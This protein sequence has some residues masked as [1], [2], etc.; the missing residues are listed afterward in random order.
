MTNIFAI[1][2]ATNSVTLDN[3]REGE[4]AFTVS[5]SS[6]RPLRARAQVVAEGDASSDWFTLQG[7][8]EREL[9]IAG[10]EQVTV[11][12]K[13]ANEVT[14]GTYVFR[15]NMVGVVNPD[16]EFGE[17]PTVTLDIPEPVIEKKKF[18]WW[19]LIVILMV[20]LI[21]GAA[22]FFLLRG[23]EPQVTLAEV[24][25]NSETAVAGS[26][27]SYTITISNT[28][29]SPAETVVFTNTLPVGTSFS[30]ISGADCVSGEA[31]G[32]IGCTLSEAIS[33]GEASEIDLVL[34]VAPTTRGFITNTVRLGEVTLPLS[35][36]VTAQT[37]LAVSLG[38]PQP[39][40]SAFIYDILVSNEGPS[41]ATGVVVSYEKTGIVFNADGQGAETACE[42]TGESLLCDLGDI[43][44]QASRPLTLTVQP[45]SSGIL[46]ATV[47]VQSNEGESID[48]EEVAV[49]VAPASE[50]AI[51]V[52]TTPSRA[53]VGEE[54]SYAISILNA[55]ARPASNVQVT[56]NVPAGAN[57]VDAQ[58]ESGDNCLQSL[59]RARIECDLG[60]IPAIAGDE[61]GTKTV[62]LI[63]QVETDGTLENNITVRSNEFGSIDKM[64]AT[65]V[66]KA[67]G[68]T[69]IRMDGLNDWAELSAF[70]IPESFTIE[71]WLN[72]DTDRDQQ[73]FI[74]KHSAE[75]N[76]I[77]LI[78]YFNNGLYVNI[79]DETFS[80]GGRAAG[81]SH[82]Q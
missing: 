35:S 77:F 33:R 10:T 57:F 24:T 78:G 12:V 70:A 73:S 18:P 51:D 59:D 55:T 65:L 26:E 15:L 1:T 17:G 28:G 46:T 11:K 72:P 68:S 37:N 44:P 8:V 16:E 58:F 19:I 13:V 30:R 25:T 48:S 4:V 3:K 45:Q 75:G 50:L 63:L 79:R 61:P 43:A 60:S 66:D 71:M 9:A 82:W 81:L 31:D 64:E 6:G 29:R 54:I 34:T 67:F 14:S 22:A 69:G 39:V 23:G 41:Q 62:T 36:T 32:E 5:N 21:G 27:L 49:Q 80:A 47:T 38:E 7:N 2:A 42:D 74:G 52:E 56:Y 53:V 76:N 40:E 20:L